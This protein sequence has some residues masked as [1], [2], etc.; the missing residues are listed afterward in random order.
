MMCIHHW[1]VVSTNGEGIRESGDRHG[2][3]IKNREITSIQNYV[4]T[5]TCSQALVGIFQN[6]IL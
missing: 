3:Y 2:V 4:T 1:N 5:S 6:M